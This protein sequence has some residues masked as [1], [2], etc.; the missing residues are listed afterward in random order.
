VQKRRE[1]KEPVC[2]GFSGSKTLQIPGS[3]GFSVELE[4]AGRNSARPALMEFFPSAVSIIMSL[5]SMSLHRH[6]F[7]EREEERE[8]GHFGT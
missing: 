4:W 7:I 6:G 5:I 3:F 8:G 2:F 1:K